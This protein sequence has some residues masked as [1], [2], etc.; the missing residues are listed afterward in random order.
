MSCYA[1]RIAVVALLMGIS[2]RAISYAVPNGGLPTM[3]WY[4]AH[5]LLLVTPC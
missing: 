2:C 4:V 5:F 1:D 3:V